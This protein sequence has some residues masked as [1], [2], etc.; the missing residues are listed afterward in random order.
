[1]S[2]EKR[3]L[4]EAYELAR[5]GTL[6]LGEDWKG[7]LDFVDHWS[8]SSATM[9]DRCLEQWRHRYILGE[10]QKP[11]AALVLGN[12]YHHAAETNFRQKIESHEDVDLETVTDAYAAEWGAQLEKEGGIAEIEW[13]REKPGAVKDTGAKLVASYHTRVAPLVQ[14]VATET[15]FEIAV[16]GVEV[17][18]IGYIDVETERNVIDHK[19]ARATV[20]SPKAD[21]RLQGDLY[22]IAREKP[23]EW[24]IAVKSGGGHIVT[25]REEPGLRVDYD[26]DRL[27]VTSAYLSRVFTQIAGAFAVYGPDRPWPGALTHPWACSY[28]GYQPRCAWWGHTGE[29]AA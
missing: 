4:V 6:T 18:V 8:A 16:E 11:G 2:N 1:M 27:R 28:C 25:S 20:R 15:S 22:Q 26:E 7:L 23:V 19:T 29:K 9:A 3:V 5:E 21:W 12:S 10:K 24:H 13:G 17:P 14:P